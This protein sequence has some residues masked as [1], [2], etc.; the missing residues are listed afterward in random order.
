M[1]YEGLADIGGFLWWVF[2][3]FCQSK[4]EEEQTKEYWARNIFF[5]CVI[6]ILIGFVSVRILKIK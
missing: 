3:K 1:R 6:G 4:L 2:I 5:L